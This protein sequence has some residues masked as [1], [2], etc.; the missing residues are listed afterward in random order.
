MT[1]YNPAHAGQLVQEWL[2]G[3]KDEGT[4]VTITEL[5][6]GMHITRAALSRMLNGH[7][8]LTADMALRLQDALGIDA[9]LLMRV[10]AAYEIWQASQQPRPLIQHLPIHA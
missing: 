7:T 3:L 8:T 1:M 6:K 5:A 2:N 9:G 10:Q 4:P